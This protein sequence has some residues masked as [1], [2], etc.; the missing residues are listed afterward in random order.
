VT[1][2][3]HEKS[4]WPSLGSGVG[5]ELGWSLVAGVAVASA[6]GVALAEELP[7][8]EGPAE[9]HATRRRVRMSAG[10]RARGR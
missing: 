8:P 10:V 1:G 4:P 3:S 2:R 7:D 6:V 9:V 5:S